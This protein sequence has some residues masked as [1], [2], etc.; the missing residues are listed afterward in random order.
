LFP[1]PWELQ[2]HAQNSA[3]LEFWASCL[4]ALS[5]GDPKLARIHAADGSRFQY[6]F[7]ATS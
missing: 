2:V 4:P 1:G 7:V 5:S 6:S 3:A